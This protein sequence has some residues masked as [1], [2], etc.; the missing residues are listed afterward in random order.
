M[1]DQSLTAAPSPLLENAIAC[2]LPPCAREIV[3][4]DLREIYRT[5]AQYAVEALRTVPL[6]VLSA[7]WRSI[8]LPLLLLQGG[9]IFAALRGLQ[10]IM[11]FGTLDCLAFTLLTLLTLVIRDTWRRP[12]RPAAQ[13]A[14]RQAILAGVF[15][16]LFCPAAFGLRD[17]HPGIAD[18]LLQF[19]LLTVLPL[20][21]PLFG[22]LRSWLIVGGDHVLDE[23]ADR[24]AGHDLRPDYHAFLLR[25]RR[26]HLTEA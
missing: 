21:V 5:P 12:T 10:A 26:R 19:Q 22:L 13:N 16:L 24:A 17:T 3:L 8:N 25:L 4:G 15:L 9:L 7:A 1:E 11:P 14:V 2:T 18:A 6:V 23:F 20:A